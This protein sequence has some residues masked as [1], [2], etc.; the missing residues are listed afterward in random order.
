MEE[1]WTEI[2][3]NLSNIQLK[4]EMYKRYEMPLKTRKDLSYRIKQLSDNLKIIEN[5]INMSKS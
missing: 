3:I 5:N 2:N 4:E 1:Q